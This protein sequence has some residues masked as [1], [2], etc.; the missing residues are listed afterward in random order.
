MTGAMKWF[1]WL[2]YWTGLVGGRSQ[3]C[4]GDRHGHEPMGLGRRRCIVL[5]CSADGPGVAEA[6]LWRDPVM[7]PYQ[8]LA[9][10]A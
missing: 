8:R 7:C 1:V 10:R 4:P 2:L 9:Y 6:A 5:E 3:L